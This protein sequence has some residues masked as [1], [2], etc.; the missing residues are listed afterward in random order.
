MSCSFQKWKS[1]CEQKWTGDWSEDG[2]VQENLWFGFGV[3]SVAEVID[4]AIWA[5]AADDGGS[6]WGVNRLALG[7]DRDGAVIVDADAGLLAPDKGPPRTGGGG[8]QY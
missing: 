2:A 7:A 3:G 5:Q 8:A 1:V 6:G 4:V